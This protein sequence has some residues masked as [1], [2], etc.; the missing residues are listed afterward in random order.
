MDGSS[1]SLTALPMPDDSS[2]FQSTE[3]LSLKIP[4]SQEI[5]DLYYVSLVSS[6]ITSW[7]WQPR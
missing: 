7:L 1:S 5:A 4:V 6:I 3:A 2:P